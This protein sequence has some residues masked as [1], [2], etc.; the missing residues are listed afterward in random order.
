MPIERFYIKRN[1]LQPYYSMRLL[2]SNE[3]TLTI[4]ATYNDASITVESTE[5]FPVSG[6]I[7]LSDYVSVNYSGKSMSTFTGCTWA[8][9]V[10]AQ[11]FALDTQVQEVVNLAGASIR[12]TL[13]TTDGTKKVNRQLAT[14]TSSAL[15]DCEYRWQTGD[16]DTVG[17]YL[18]EF[19]VTPSTS[20]KFTVPV[21]EKAIVV[22][23]P[24]LD[25]T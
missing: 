2:G 8:G 12:F 9:G 10:T 14:I 17:T 24:D 5:G 4:Q 23:I 3:T 15:G 7:I 16:T 1:D 18:A 20:P 19:E 25:A 11:I 22:I 21:S 13:S 6:N